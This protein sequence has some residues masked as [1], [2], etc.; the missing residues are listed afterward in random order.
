MID[1]ERH[2]RLI[3]EFDMPLRVLI[4]FVLK[5]WF[6][7]QTTRQGVQS[8]RLVAS[9]L[10]SDRT[11]VIVGCRMPMVSNLPLAG[12]RAGWHPVGA[13]IDG[14]V[15]AEFCETPTHGPRPNHWTPPRFVSLG[16]GRHDVAARSDG[17]LPIPRVSFDLAT[18]EVLLVEFYPALWSITGRKPARIDV[19]DGVD[20]VRCSSLD[21]SAF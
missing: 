12:V 7:D 4:P 19:F 17:G 13:M 20:S 18:N 16:I 14:E 2:R 8:R 10:R 9:M 6:P 21:Q 1:V 15:V 11:G 5:H 3:D